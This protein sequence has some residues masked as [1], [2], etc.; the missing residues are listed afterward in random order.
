MNFVASFFF[1]QLS[2]SSILILMKS[3]NPNFEMS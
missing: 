3:V 1:Q 2:F